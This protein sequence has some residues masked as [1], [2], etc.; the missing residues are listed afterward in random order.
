MLLGIV[1]VGLT[2]QAVRCAGHWLVLRRLPIVTPAEFAL[3]EPGTDV[4]LTGRTAAGPLLRSPETRR[5]CV[6]YLYVN[7]RVYH[8]SGEGTDTTETIGAGGGDARIHGDAGP[9]VTIDPEPGRRKLF[10][11]RDPMMRFTVTL[12][13]VNQESA[14]RYGGDEYYD[15][16]YITEAD[17]PITAAGRV[18]PGRDRLEPGRWVT[19]TA[20]AEVAALGRHTLI[21]VL[22]FLGGAAALSGL[23]ILLLW[24]R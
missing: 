1:A 13:H 18:G 20:T 9:A 14:Q 5:D 7:V 10:D 8:Y 23:I 12:N 21:E 22:A 15:R 6:A 11:T 24:L 2:G 19:G 4:I 17:L 3:A 16:E